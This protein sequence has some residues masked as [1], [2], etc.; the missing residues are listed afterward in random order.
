MDYKWDKGWIGINFFN[1]DNS[2]GCNISIEL[3][4]YLKIFIEMLV[5]F[6][7]IFLENEFN[8]L[9]DDVFFIFNCLV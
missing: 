1:L 8:L 3:E 4:I 2:T 7:Y 9:W 6:N 5:I